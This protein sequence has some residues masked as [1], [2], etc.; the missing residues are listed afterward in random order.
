[1][2]AYRLEVHGSSFTSIGVSLGFVQVHW[3][4]FSSIFEEDLN[5][6]AVVVV[7]VDVEDLLALDAQNTA[8]TVS[9]TFQGMSLT[10]TPRRRARQQHAASAASRHRVIAYQAYRGSHV[11]RQNTLGQSY[12]SLAKKKSGAPLS[13]DDGPHAS[14]ALDAG[15][16][17]GQDKRRTGERTSAQHDDIVFLCNLIHDGRQLEAG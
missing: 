13:C 2:V 9:Q 12:S 17:N 5:S 1:M 8:R 10:P 16:S 7:A 11:P 15:V 3:G 6:P 4:R 14:K